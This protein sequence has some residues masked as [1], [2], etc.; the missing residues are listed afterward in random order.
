VLGDD[1]HLEDIIYIYFS[2]LFV[3]Y[4]SLTLAFLKKFSLSFAEGYFFSQT[5]AVCE[6]KLLD[7][8]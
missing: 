6:A 5:I 3:L 8:G 1:K 7:C 4:T 2:V